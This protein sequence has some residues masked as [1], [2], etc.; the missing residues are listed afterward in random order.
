MEADTRRK[1]TP[2]HRY[3][4]VANTGKVTELIEQRGTLQN[5]HEKALPYVAKGR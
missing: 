3:L 2:G 4:I 1:N 5:V